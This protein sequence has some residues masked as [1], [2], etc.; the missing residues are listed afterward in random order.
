MLKVNIY[1]I[2]F[3]TFLASILLTI[4]GADFYSIRINDVLI[5]VSI[6]ILLLTGNLRINKNLQFLFICTFILLNMSSFNGF[7]QGHFFRPEGAIFYIKYISIFIILILSAEFSK[8]LNERKMIANAIFYLFISL[9]VW[10]YIYLYLRS[11]AIL[12]GNFRASFPF[13]SDFYISDAHVYSSLLG[14]LIFGY[15]YYI[16]QMLDHGY[17]FSMGVI[18]FSVIS[19]ILTGSRGGLAILIIGFLIMII[20]KMRS[21][22]LINKLRVRSLLALLFFILT[23][24]L[25]LFFYSDAVELNLYA[26][27]IERATN[28]DLTSDASSISRVQ[29]L[30]VALDDW[31]AGG[32]VLGL[33]VFSCSLTWYDGLTSILLAHGGLSLLLLFIFI[34]IFTFY[35]I[36]ITK[37]IETR[38]KY[39]LCAIILMYLMANI[40][41]E[42]IL[43]SRNMLPVLTLIV[44]I[45]QDSKKSVV[46]TFGS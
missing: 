8:T 12:T 9:V 45:Y 4:I 7:F 3:Y 10:V 33:G 37:N 27:L 35:L 24:F 14:M 13:S 46:D 25:I 41:T 1:N 17:L 5:W 38:N 39:I 15:F 18:F 40:I 30:G 19:T 21:I 44:L 26:S 22:F 23:L 29:K 31:R 11:I 2:A 32:Y 36:V 20:Y 16:R 28:F 34:L 6:L 43:I 42:Y